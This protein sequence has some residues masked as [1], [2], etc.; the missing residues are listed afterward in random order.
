[1]G[2]VGHALSHLQIVAYVES[3]E[4]NSARALIESLLGTLTVKVA[5]TM[6]E[7]LEVLGGGGIQGLLV[8]LPG[9]EALDRI[10]ALRARVLDMPLIA[11]TGTDEDHLGF[12]AIDAGAD[13]HLAGRML[14]PEDLARAISMALARARSRE[15]RKAD[16]EKELRARQKRLLRHQDL[17]KA[18]AKHEGMGSDDLRSVLCAI[19]EA[20]T[21]SLGV[22]RA[23]VWVYTDG[24]S[25][26]RALDLYEAST[27]KHSEGIDLAASSYPEYFA[28]LE[29]ERTIVAHD[30][31][32]DPATRCFAE[33]YLRPL[34]ITSMLD[35]P[36][37]VGGRAHG[38]LCQEHVGP[39]RVWTEDEQS[40]A[41]GLADFVS[42]ALES[43]ERKQAEQALRESREQLYQAQKME[44]VGR[45][46]GGIAHDFNNILT[47]ILGHSAYLNTDL[48]PDS[49]LREIASEIFTAGQRAA[50]MTSQL[51]A[52]SRRQ[53]LEPR[54][55]D[56]NRV[57]RDM[58]GMLCRLI[59][60]DI[61]LAMEPMARMGRIMADPTKMEQVILN[62]V[63][64][65]RDA[66]PDGG[67]ITIRTRNEERS[68]D[69]PNGARENKN[70][71]V[72]SVI[73]RGTG[74]D[75]SILGHIFEPFFTTKDPGKG[76]GLGLSTVYG[77]VKQS[78]G[79]LSVESTKGQGSVFEATFP[80]HALK[81]APVETPP[82]VQ[83]AVGGK[84][85]V[86]LVEDDQQVRTLTRAGL[87]KLGYLVL[88]AQ[89]IDEAVAHCKNHV[90]VIDILVSDVVMPKASGPVV[91]ERVRE[92]WPDV[93]VLFVSGYTADALARYGE[94]LSSGMLLGKPY[95][96]EAL[97]R[98]IR[99][100]LACAGGYLS[101][102]PVDQSRA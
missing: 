73:D 23:S 47:V 28:A 99:E 3:A 81:L 2:T 96:V 88:P 84:E 93:Q 44:A 53:V 19:T 24:R 30:A 90:G 36:V 6:Q 89:D 61:E 87:E 58:E 97:A 16:A 5:R 85:T 101:P 27:G 72:L 31:C 43:Y 56:L 71:V 68:V 77:I 8:F 65:A 13:D 54:I 37:R 7:T 98:K 34:G 49:P 9:S 40:M 38:V 26:I 92:L 50:H 1:M 75:P 57:V 82:P 62:L 17:L 55:V 52:L 29:T 59:G 39:M 64:N 67:K 70:F 63:V 11:F 48:P 46:A 25:G 10:S 12:R 15:K 79:D 69:L 21:Q 94:A 76:T 86:L 66:M 14:N 45:L 100:S 80:A 22:E 102:R 18:L 4:A 60:E 74:M 42:L 41:G 32:H 51:L 35:A 33:S 78:G 91:A 95:T 83:V 20:A